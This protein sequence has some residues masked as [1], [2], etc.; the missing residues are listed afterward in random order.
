LTSTGNIFG[1][2][3]YM[4]PEQCQGQNVDERSDIYSFGCVLYECLAGKP[5]FQGEPLQVMF[6]HLHERPAP[7]EHGN[8]CEYELKLVAEQCME[9]DAGNRFQTVTAMLDALGAIE[10][11]L[12]GSDAPSFTPSW[13][14][15]SQPRPTP[16]PQS[17]NIPN[18]P[19]TRQA[20]S[21]LITKQ[22][23]PTWKRVLGIFFLILVFGGIPIQLY[24][25]LKTW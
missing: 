14:L 10:S 19:A 3:L 8:Q 4:S 7:I 23:E 6:K 11:K 1:S 2:P 25:W 17:N 20:N 22:A 9:K 18:H 16:A 15:P 5:P 12:R 21:E 24:L 13:P